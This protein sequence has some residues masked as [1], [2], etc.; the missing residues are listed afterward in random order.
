MDALPPELWM[1][2][3]G[4]PRLMAALDAERGAT[5][6][7]GGSVRDWLLDMPVSDVDLATVFAPE[8]VMRRLDAAGIRHVP[9][10]LR[11]G[12]VSAILGGQAY[13]VTTL[14][15]DVETDG[16]HATVA[17]TA[18]WMEDARRRD[19]T[20]NALYVE[21]LNGT[22]HDYFN[23]RS[24]IAARVVRFIGDPLQRIAEDHLRILRFFR[25]SAR[26]S[27][28]LEPMG[29]AACAGR[30]ADL[31]HLSME[32]V[33]DELFKLLLVEKPL[34]VL[35]A[36]LAAGILAPVLPEITSTERLSALIG[37]EHRAGIRGDAIRRLAALIPALTV[38]TRDVALAIAARL[39]LSNADRNRLCVIS[40]VHAV[41]RNPEALAYA[42]GPQ[43]T[44]DC[45]L[46]TG[47]PRAGEWAPRLATWHRPRL[48]IG[49]RD[50]IAM[51]VTPGPEIARL[52][53]AVENIWIG[54]GF[55]ADRDRL[56]AEARRIAGFR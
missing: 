51:G 47:D 12:T 21:P 6:I 23:G 38:E 41:P 8:E 7:V 1:E 29:F 49:G 50:I 35:D 14:R 42:I 43:A 25:F 24:D 30:A 40:T 22:V 44:L 48:P 52:I 33:R 37:A 45:M 34:P 17:F 39:R 27:A 15:R 3:P 16:R 46:L 18:E 53:A 4:F 56:L 9:T 19:F 36:M 28:S 31:R 2:R 32:R 55:N 10:G 5:R 20:I 11:H 54:S 26:Y 13:E